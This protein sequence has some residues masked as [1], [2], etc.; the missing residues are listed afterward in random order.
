MNIHSISHKMRFVVKR[1]ILWEGGQGTF[2][3]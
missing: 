2:A 3:R 1:L